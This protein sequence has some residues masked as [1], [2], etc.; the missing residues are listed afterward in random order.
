MDSQYEI[1]E[2]PS[3]TINIPFK[4]QDVVDIGEDFT[5]GTINNDL[6][7]NGKRYGETDYTYEIGKNTV[8]AEV[9]TPAPPKPADFTISKTVDNKKD[10]YLNGETV[11]FKIS[12]TNIGEQPG[13]ITLTDTIPEAYQ[14][15][16]SFVEIKDATAIDKNNNEITIDNNINNNEITF[17]NVQPGATVS[18]KVTCTVNV[19]E[20]KTLTNQVTAGKKSAYADINVKKKIT[21][22]KDGYV[23][24]KSDNKEYIIGEKNDVTYI[25]TVKNNDNTGAE[26]FSFTDNVPTY[27]DVKEVTISK[28]NSGITHTGNEVKAEKCKIGAGEII[29]VTIKGTISDTATDTIVNTLTGTGEDKNPSVEFKGETR[30]VNL[31]IFKYAV[32]GNKYVAGQPKQF[33]I[34]VTNSGD[35]KAENVTVN[36]IPATEITIDGITWTSNNA[37]HTE[38]N[39]TKT[40]NELKIAEILPGEKITFTVNTTIS[41]TATGDITNKATL[42]Y[43]GVPKESSTKITR[44]NSGDYKAEKWIVDENGETLVD[45]NGNVKEGFEGFSVGDKI[46]FR[47]KFTNNSTKTIE[48][49]H[50]L[51]YCKLAHPENTEDKIEFKII[52]RIDNKEEKTYP[53]DIY[54]IQPSYGV[55]GVD[56]NWKTTLD[57]INM[58]T[59]ESITLEYSFYINE[60]I[61]DTNPN[62]NEWFLQNNIGFTD[63]EYVNTLNDGANLAKANVIIPR[64]FTFTTTK[65]FNGDSTIDIQSTLDNFKDTNYTYYIKINPND[66]DTKDYTNSTFTITD[67]LPDGMDFNSIDTTSGV[68]GD[69]TAKQDGKKLTF[70]FKPTLNGTKLSGVTIAYKTKLTPEKAEQIFNTASAKNPVSLTNTVTKINVDKFNKTYTPNSTATITFTKKAP[71]PGFAKLA[72]ASFAGQTFN[73]ETELNYVNNGYITAGDTLIWNLVLYNG[74]GSYIDK[75]DHSK[76]KVYDTTNT[77]DIDLSQI[78]LTDYLPNGYEYSTSTGYPV[79]A[80]IIDLDD[81]GDYRQ[82]VYDDKDNKV[83][84]QEYKSGNEFKNYTIKPNGNKI[85]VSFNG[86]TL[87]PNECIVIEF[88]TTATKEREGVVTNNGEATFKNDNIKITNESIVAGERKDDKTIFNSANYN[89]VGLTT[90]SWKTITYTNQGHNGD[91]HTDPA[92]DTGY[93][94]TPT[95]NY[96]QGMQGEDVTYELHVKN[97]SPL[98]LENFVLIDRLPY[99][100][101][102]G[103]VSGYSRNSA[104]SVNLASNP[105]FE[106]KIHRAGTAEGV[107]ETLN[108]DNYDIHYSTDKTAVLDEYSKDWVG[109]NDKMT[110]TKNTANAVDFRIAFK[111]IIVNANDEVVIT[112]KGT[113]PS[114]VENTGEENIAWNSFAYAYQNKEI[115]GSTVMVAEP[116]KVGV[117]VEKPQTENKIIIN[118]KLNESENESKTFYFALFGDNTGTKRISDV[119]SLTVPAGQTEASVTMENLDYT[120]IKK[121]NNISDSDNIYLLETNA[122]GEV[123]DNSKSA[124][125][126]GYTGNTI[127][128][129]KA[130]NTVKVTNEKQTK[131]ITVTK[132]LEGTTDTDT[133]YFA[134][135]TKETGKDDKPVF[136][137]YEEAG[138]KS[139]TMPNT[140]NTLNFDIPATGSYY[141]FET[142]ENGVL[143]DEISADDSQKYY[144]GSQSGEKYNVT[145][146]GLA[147]GNNIEITND[148]VT[149]YS[150][151]VSKSLSSDTINT[152]PTFY[153][154]LYKNETDTTTDKVKAI[155]AGEEV[156]FEYLD[157]TTTYYVFECDK[158][159]K[160]YTEGSF[161]QEVYED[162][163]AST[164]VEHTFTI[165]YENNTKLTFNDGT[166]GKEK[167]TSRNVSITNIDGVKNKINVTKTFNISDISKR[168]GTFY[169]GVFTYN[170]ETKKYTKVAVKDITISSDKFTNNVYTTATPITFDSLETNKD[171]Y[172]FETDKQG[173]IIATENSVFN[174]FLVNYNGSN[175]VRLDGIVEGSVNITNTYQQT[176]PITF[177][178]Y[179]V[180]GNR[181]A[182]AAFTL[183]SKTDIPATVKAENVTISEN[184]ITWTTDG[185]KDITITGLPEGK[186]TLTETPMTGFKNIEA[187]EFTINSNGYIET[188]TDTTEDSYTVSANSVTVV[189]K[190]EISISKKD[191]AEKGNADAKEIKG[192]LI[193]VERTDGNKLIGDVKLSRASTKFND[194]AVDF[195]TDGKFNSDN[196]KDWARTDTKIGFYSDGENPTTITGLPDGSYKMTEVVAPTNYE[197]LTTTLEFTIENGVVKTSSA[198]ENYKADGN[199]ITMFD[200]ATLQNASISIVKK[201]QSKDGEV[202]SGALFRITT[203]DGAFDEI[204]LTRQSVTFTEAT[205]NT[206]NN[207]LLLK[208]TETEITSETANYT[209]YYG[210]STDKKTLLFYS[211]ET[212]ILNNLTDGTYELEELVAP[213]GYQKTFDTMT[214]TVDKGKI[215]VETDNS[216]VYA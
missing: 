108:G 58:N 41:D 174:S 84:G 145:G 3:T 87:K 194:T 126:V 173:S 86:G 80:M 25:I 125:S 165:Q 116:A 206:D 172:V 152:A 1:A 163:T 105:E 69:V 74:D 144:T 40:D 9:V 141:I 93:S 85:D 103:L 55:G 13:N 114:F 178:K 159:G 127:D 162:K 51:D 184:T 43:N 186:Y 31:G 123:I 50:V 22:S 158:N 34:E 137:R 37:K 57:N 88:V 15:K 208:G 161:K 209:T 140:S 29:T 130:E 42:N 151:T 75:N 129:T 180:L 17:T 188:S 99:V 70:T 122:K 94:R 6:T 164:T 182:G 28:E 18:A 76:G 211:D 106:V 33:I 210:I 12:A 46:T 171:Y 160:K 89:I 53:K 16:L 197:K 73:N 107:Y 187:L 153:V 113:V 71:A 97:N 142:N 111:N 175:A 32:D 96:V 48:D 195:D 157:S 149:N 181:M 101:D 156:T 7:V 78:T 136:V 2:M 146:A 90:E 19:D 139:L 120:S 63:N 200:T 191:I 47:A 216:S 65:T 183:T 169:F 179:D 81:K 212:T 135:F 207:G 202:L 11:T 133:F 83:I 4:L 213:E 118:K 82:P 10:Y 193:T 60:S 203:T 39:V 119:I 177:A 26:T 138:I 198:D 66:K 205:I 52:D 167:I 121:A 189:N 8:S 24:E 124:Y 102:I 56:N 104:F 128:T 21:I 201:A 30:K 155:S 38:S 77:A 68:D 154:G 54:Q 92:T 95:H 170:N 67:E 150:I 45:A 166:N 204:P 112:F 185:T 91:P 192:A 49:L 143:V 196:Y 98:S 61:N 199:T 79:K 134:V 5:G 190:S 176:V 36:E 20:T 110:W 117:W 44:D 23:G 35:L 115:L 148:K 131:Q 64:N 14:G 109:Q 100:N 168:T 27:V 215:T 59:G 72:Y 132:K 62:L 214:I 147:T